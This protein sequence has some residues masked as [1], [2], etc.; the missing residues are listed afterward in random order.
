M[1]DP[2]PTLTVLSQPQPATLGGNYRA[3][4]DHLQRTRRKRLL[5]AVGMTVL[6]ALFL[7]LPT[8]ILPNPI[9]AREVPIRWWEYPVVAVTCALTWAW[10]MVQTPPRQPEHHGRLLTALTVTL[11]A[12]AC[13]VCNKIV[14]LTIGA[15]GAL[16]TWAPLQPYLALATLIALALALG[17]RIRSAR[18]GKTN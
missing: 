15:A 4:S 14:L 9:F 12:V 8:S 18:S 16:S 6:T 2:H 11:F 1:T 3:N 10:F 17:L 5:T 13:P 7:T